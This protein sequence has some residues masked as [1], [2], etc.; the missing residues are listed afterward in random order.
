ME[1][2]KS[3]KKL[4]LILWI[5]QIFIAILFLMAGLTKATSPMED[6]QK[7]MNW[8]TRFPELVVRFIGVAELLGA[9]GLILPSLVR[10]KPFLTVWAAY[11]L[12]TIMILASIFHFMHAEYNFIGINLIFAFFAGFIA[13]G[14]S[15]KVIIQSR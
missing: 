9:L 15:K 11:G 1:T 12:L 6:L 2:A 10:I 14:R 5:T 13:W 4:N 7:Q 8:V 3:L